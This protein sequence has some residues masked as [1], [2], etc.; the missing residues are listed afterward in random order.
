MK[1]V[2]LN[3]VTGCSYGFP[4]PFLACLCEIPYSR[5]VNALAYTTETTRPGVYGVPSRVSRAYQHAPVVVLQR[6]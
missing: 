5:P 1:M 3:S 2:S 6:V 4:L